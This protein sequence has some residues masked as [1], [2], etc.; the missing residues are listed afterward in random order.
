MDSVIL[1]Q[2]NEDCRSSSNFKYDTYAVSMA[3][4]ISQLLS[5]FIL[6]TEGLEKWCLIVEEEGSA[7]IL[8]WPPHMR[9]NPERP[10]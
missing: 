3:N 6:I 10:L 9:F 4:N 7:D 8:W 1:Y 2:Q 5:Y